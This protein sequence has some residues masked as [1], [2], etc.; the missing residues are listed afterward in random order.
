MPQSKQT[1]KKSKN[2]RPILLGFAY[3]YKGN[4]GKLAIGFRWW[5]ILTAMLCSA[6]AAWLLVAGVLYFYF[7]Y[8]KEFDEVSYVGMLTLPSRIDAHRKEMGDYHV[9]KGMEELEKQNYRDALRLLRLGVARA[10][11]NLEGRK[12]LAEIYEAWLKRPDVS[13]EM[14]IQGIKAGGIQ[15][16]DYVKSTLR[17]L[18][19]QQMDSDIQDLADKHIPTTEDPII[20]SILAFGA[21][22]ANYLRG[23]YD[24]ADDYL[25]EYGL[26]DSMEG[27]L[28]SSQIS[29]DRNNRLAAITK[30]EDALRKY[31]DSEAILVQL[32]RYHR[33]MG[34]MDASLRYSILRN[35]R[36]PLSAGPR[37]ELLYSYRYNNELERVKTE[38]NKI[39]KQFSDDENAL[40]AL[41]NFAADTGD[42][43]IARRAYEEALE[44]EFQIDAFALLLIEAH[45][46]NKDYDG[47]LA[48]A[49][50]LLKERPEWLQKRWSIFN[51]LRSVASYGIDRPDLGEIY[52]QDFLQ[53]ESN[54]AQTYL[55][56]A[57]R[58]DTINRPEQARKVLRT[59]YSKIPGNQKILS[60][61][62]RLDLQLGYT[63]NLSELISKLL[64]MR[65]PQMELLYEAYRKIGSD[66]FIFAK[67]REA[68]LTQLSAI[69]RENSSTLYKIDS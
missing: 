47:A 25:L 21:A 40:Q 52:L 64:Q 67:D 44:R 4:N 3:Q 48:F 7:K 49:E 15:D 28:L 6:L 27:I 60:E 23:N 13:A 8:T 29:W 20:Q 62:I 22:N 33:E 17:L 38:A 65:R 9:R 18:L 56:V 66:R 5:R 12:I 26:L 36:S 14:M 68:I 58:F 24:L 53:E 35:I 39:L 55:A 2:I 54:Q 37:V 11:G 43:E 32:S 69:L 45:L 50:E 59:A 51:S 41:A 63:E 46:V 42:I 57:R 34:N 61:L 10:P 30:L 1:L 19:R 16:A 31:P